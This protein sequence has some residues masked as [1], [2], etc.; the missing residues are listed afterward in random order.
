MLT[1]VVNNVRTFKRIYDSPVSE[2]TV[3]AI[4][5]NEDSCSQHVTTFQAPGQ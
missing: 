3:P 1:E 5:A 2:N 4:S